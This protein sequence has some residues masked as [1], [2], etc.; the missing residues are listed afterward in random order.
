[1]T[2]SRDSHPRGTVTP[3]HDTRA[4][5][6]VTGASSG[7]GRSVVSHLAGSFR[8]IAVARR[9]DRL[10]E[11][12]GSDD[13]V[14][15]CSLDLL[16]LSAVRDFCKEVL[17]AGPVVSHII[18]NAGINRP[19]GVTA[20]EQREW[21][22]SVIVNAFAPLT[23]MR[24][25]LPDMRARGF[26]R[27]VDVTSGAPLNCFAGYGAY[28]G[29]KALLNALTVTA[30]REFEAEDIRINLMSPG[31]VRSEMA[32]RAPLDPSACHPT[33]DFLLTLPADG[34]TGRCFWLGHEVPLFPDLAGVD[35]LAGEANGKLRRA[36]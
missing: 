33:V 7:V 36:F 15:I 9:G 21:D 5:V 1:M 8:V 2:D 16:N 27:I 14:V 17:E 23:I 35:W 20:L 6:P 34:P 26:G 10:E 24:S 12:F 18:N 32:P 13:D 22:E 29:S 4:T 25:F 19:G 11:A 3:V 30:A 31:P 28:S